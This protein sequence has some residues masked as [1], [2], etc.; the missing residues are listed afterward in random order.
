MSTMQQTNAIADIRDMLYLTL[1]PE[2]VGTWL[3]TAAAELGGRT[4][5]ACLVQGEF[6]AVYACALAL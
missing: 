1:A 6:P 2:E 4:P 3:G 5:M